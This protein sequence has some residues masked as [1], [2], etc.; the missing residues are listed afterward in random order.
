M[1]MF[2]YGSKSL[3]HEENARVAGL[4]WLGV[5]IDDILEASTTSAN[6]DFLASFP[7]ASQTSDEEH[8]QDA[9]LGESANTSKAPETS[10]QEADLVEPVAPLPHAYYS[11]HRDATDNMMVLTG[12]D[13]KKTQRLLGNMTTDAHEEFDTEQSEQI[14]ELQL[15]L[16][17]NLKAEI[18]AIDDMGDLSTWLD[19]KMAAI[20]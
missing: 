8:S 11:V 18:Q 9:N 3:S 20:C 2:K 19:D 14:R 4:Q 10:G 12:T 5:R 15:M 17:L 6:E 7:M 16:M 13:R 1:R